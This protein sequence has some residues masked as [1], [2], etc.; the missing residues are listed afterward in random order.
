MGSVRT[1]GSTQRASATL[2]EDVENGHATAH[3]IVHGPP[4]PPTA[5]VVCMI[6][7]NVSRRKQ[8]ASGLLPRPESRA[9]SGAEAP[10]PPD[11]Q[12]SLLVEH[13]YYREIRVRHDAP[14]AKLTCDP[15]CRR[16]NSGESPGRCV[17][18]FANSLWR[19]NR[20][21]FYYLSDGASTLA[22]RSLRY[23]E[24]RIA[25]PQLKRE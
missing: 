10:S 3:A 8:C 1:E 9:A 7:R 5:L 12:P 17:A 13:T 11:P 20:G 16:A 23:N 24:L 25:P 18:Q 22:R 14:E 15:P 4:A 2:A 21:N 6:R 19:K